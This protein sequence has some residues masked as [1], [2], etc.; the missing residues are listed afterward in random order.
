MWDGHKTI[1]KLSFFQGRGAREEGIRKLQK[2]VLTTNGTLLLDNKGVSW[3]TNG[4][5]GWSHAAYVISMSFNFF[6]L[7]VFFLHPFLQFS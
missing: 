7:D 2:F 3:V 6:K 5:Q 1:F 4:G